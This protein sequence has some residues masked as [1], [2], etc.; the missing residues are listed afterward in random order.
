LASDAVS[1]GT[2]ISG[3]VLEITKLAGGGA[4]SSIGSSSNAASN[5]AIDGGTLEYSGSGDSTDRL[6]TVGTGGA[7]LDSS[8]TGPVNWTNAAAVALSGGGNRTLTLA[9]AN[10]GNNTL[11]LDL[12]D[13]PGADTLALTKSGAGAWIIAGDA[14]VHEGGTAASAGTLLVNGSIADGPPATD[15]TVASGATLGGTGTIGGAVNVSG[16][17][18]LAPGAGP[19]CLD[20][21]SVTFD[22]GSNF[23][24]ELNGTSVCTDYDQLNV[25]GTVTLNNARLRAQ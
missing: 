10:T 5:L 16:G 6:F 24:V 25:T 18:M 1:C 14:N 11:T 4:N 21:G 22:A 8:G 17:G 13:P 19:E 7:T 2:T 9:G 15:V 20:T 3:G 23:N 12:A